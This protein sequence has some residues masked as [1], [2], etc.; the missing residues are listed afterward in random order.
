MHLTPDSFHSDY[1]CANYINVRMKHFRF[2]L[3][4]LCIKGYHQDKAFLAT[5][6]PMDSTMIEFWAMVWEKNSHAIVMLSLLKENEVVST[7]YHNNLMHKWF[8]H[9]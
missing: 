3:T 8:L 1:V 9:M 5:E 7:C 6:N 4:G 2:T